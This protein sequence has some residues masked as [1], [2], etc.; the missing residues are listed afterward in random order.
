MRHPRWLPP[1]P[2]QFNVFLS[3]LAVAVGLSVGSSVVTVAL[4]GKICQAE[5][6]RLLFVVRSDESLAISD[7][8]ASPGL[9]AASSL[10]AR[11]HVR[12]DCIV[13]ALTG[14]H[15]DAIGVTSR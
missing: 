13:T 12:P 2:L 4:F 8:G 5:A 9:H 14:R 3:L 7:A 1:R 11:D 6:C 15:V 10:E